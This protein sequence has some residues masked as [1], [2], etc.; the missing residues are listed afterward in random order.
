V[1]KEEW[2]GQYFFALIEI[3]A[4]MQAD[5]FKKLNDLTGGRVESKVVREIPLR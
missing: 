2:Q 4:G 5:I 1:R 3:P